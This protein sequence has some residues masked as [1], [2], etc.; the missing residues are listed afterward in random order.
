MGI[1]RGQITITNPEAETIVQSEDILYLLGA[2]D[3]LK[4]SRTLFSEG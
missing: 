2:P 1:R 3:S 4:K